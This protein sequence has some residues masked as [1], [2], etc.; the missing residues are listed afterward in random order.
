MRLANFD[1]GE[2]FI[3]RDQQLELFEL[4]LNRWKNLMF[5]AEADNIPVISTP[6]PNRKIQ[7]LIVLLYGRGGFGKST[8]LRRYREIA[9]KGNNN[10]MSSNILLSSIIDWEFAVEGKRGFFNPPRDQEIDASIYFRVLCEQLAIAFNKK[11]QDFKKYQS[12]LKDVEK[13]R[14]E[15]NGILDRLQK[16]DHYASLRALA[17]PASITLVRWIAPRIGQ[18]L[19]QIKVTEKVEEVIG[20]GAEVGAEQLL[21]LHAKL[22]DSL[23]SKLGDYLEP[24]LRLGLALGN[25]L[26]LFAR[27][28]P[29]LAFF[30]TYEEI[31]EGDQLL[32]IVM[33]AAGLRVGW[34]IAGR[35]NLWAGMDQRERSIALEY[36]Y[37][38]IVPPDRGLSVD[39][40]V[41][42]VGAFT[43]S[44]IAEYF[45]KLRQKVGGKPQLPSITEEEAGRILDVTQGVPLAVKIAAGLFLETTDLDIV[46]EK[47]ESKRKIVD[48]MV[49]RYLV[50]AR[51]DL[52]ERIQL[53][54]LALLRRAD[55]PATIASALGLTT[56]KV[57]TDYATELSRLHRRYS[58]IFSE[59]EQ[60]ALHQEVRYFLRLWLLEHRLL[61]EIMSINERLKD[62]QETILKK[63]EGDRLYVSLRERLQDD[64]WV[65]MYLDFIERQFWLDPVKGV[66]YALPYIFAASIYRRES[67]IDVV[68]IGKFFEKE[69]PQPYHKRWKWAAYCMLRR[70]NFNASREELTSLQELKKMLQQHCPRFSSKLLSSDYQKEL[71]AALYWRL[72][73][74]YER[75]NEKE[76]LEC[77]EIALIEIHD[78]D[79]LR[80]EAAHVAFSQGIKLSHE[81]KDKDSIFFYSRGIEL[82]DTSSPLYTSRGIAYSNIKEYQMAIIDF[83]RAIELDPLHAHPYTARGNV[84]LVFKDYLK[85][86]SDLDRAIELEPNNPYSYY[87]RAK[88]YSHLHQYESTITDLSQMIELDPIKAGIH[89]DEQL[90]GSAYHNRGV[91]YAKLKQYHNAIN[92]FSNAIQIFNLLEKGRTGSAVTYQDR[93]EA[94]FEL[95]EY[96]L[97]IADFNHAIKLDSENEHRGLKW[98]GLALLALDRTAEAVNVFRKALIAGPGCTECLS[99]L[100][101]AY[102]LLELHSQ[103]TSVQSEISKLEDGFQSII[104]YYNHIIDLYPNDVTALINRGVTYYILGDIQKSL[105]DLNRSLEID[106]D[107]ADAICSRGFVYNAGYDFSKAL[108]DFDHLIS[109]D[110]GR[111]TQVRED[112]ALLLNYLGRYDEAAEEY[113]ALLEDRE[114]DVTCLYNSAV[115]ITCSEGLANSQ[116]YI[117]KARTALLALLNTDERGRAL[118]GLGGLEALANDT[119]Q[120]MKHLEEA[121]MLEK[122]AVQWVRYDPAWRVLR[123]DPRHIAFFPEG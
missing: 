64:E 20:K 94:Y 55:Q 38:D 96:E 68:K 58:F 31:D 91:A 13:A 37:K 10:L 87:V 4:Y 109:V 119:D 111:M 32:R 2:I 17:G 56:E 122:Q 22:K 86:I 34:V 98:K 70:T 61:P 100:A 72:G 28:F 30:D 103:N 57:N 39:F 59:K 81:K 71:E 77:Y 21:Q 14:K 54:G 104:D 27:N 114:N 19:D 93:G 47:A 51:D 35:D 45:A 76:A 108:A 85:A 53:Y 12:A 116:T 8:L 24:E 18:A 23:G 115:A 26:R 52:D 11:P 88:V 123:T 92:D 82:D 78:E 95:K 120:A 65:E 29:L 36:G 49:R 63:L 44:D 66:E 33:A 7:N 15:A 46:T 69:I 73:E 99:S 83:N 5:I 3:G 1:I 112:R 40:N 80:E 48:Q 89:Y 113:K 41:G 105:A 106:P 67:N 110:A 101:H 117:D 97:A 79:I 25:D 121:I 16:D 90:K 42:G 50:H 6:S 75:I 84:E 43:I 62:A 107:N 102:H 118:Y 60:P 9:L 74:A